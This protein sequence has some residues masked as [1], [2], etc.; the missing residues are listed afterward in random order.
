MNFKNQ[1]RDLPGGPVVEILCFQEK[2]STPESGNEGSTCR[3]AWPREWGGGN[4]CKGWIL[5][6]NTK[7]QSQKLIYYMIIE[8]LPNDKVIVMGNR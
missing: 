4:Q 7:S 1:C 5:R 8:Q 3:M 2:G 6:A